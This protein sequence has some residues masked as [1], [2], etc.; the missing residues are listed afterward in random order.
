MKGDALLLSRVIA[1][2]RVQFIIP[3][4]QRN[5]SWLTENCNQLFN[6]LVDLVHSRQT[7]SF[8]WFYSYI[9]SRWL[10]HQSTCH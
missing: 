6:D 10:W 2:G 8:L 9:S 1:G 4:Y 5:Y 7:D 3:V